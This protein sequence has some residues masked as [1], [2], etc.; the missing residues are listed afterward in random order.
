MHCRCSCEDLKTIK[1][2]PY[3]S[4]FSYSIPPSS[5]F[6]NS[7]APS[8]FLSSPLSPPHAPSSSATPPALSSLT[9]SISSSNPTSCQSSTTHKNYPR[10]HTCSPSCWWSHWYMQAFWPN[11]FS[12]CDSLWVYHFSTFFSLLPFSCIFCPSCHVTNLNCRCSSEP[13]CSFYLSSFLIQTDN[14]QYQHVPNCSVCTRFAARRSFERAQL[15][16]GKWS[17]K[18]KLIFQVRKGENYGRE[19]YH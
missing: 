17:W 3:D 11:F 14:F 1:I 6:E 4:S 9:S 18:D 8:S 12:H 5:E 10:S 2:S 16:N 7:G 15:F 19:F 13:F